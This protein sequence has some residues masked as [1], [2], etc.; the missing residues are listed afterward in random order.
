MTA[1]RRNRSKTKRQRK[2]S[3]ARIK[4]ATSKSHKRLRRPR[5]FYN[6]RLEEALKD[7]RNGSSLAAAARKIGVPPGQLRRYI[8][9]TGVAEF[10][11]KK[12][13]FNADRRLRRLPIYSNGQRVVITVR[14]LKTA[15]RVGA[16][17]SAV[18]QFFETEDIDYL[19]PFKGQSVK[20][21][22]GKRYPFE[23]RPNVL[24]SLDAAGIEPFEIVYAIVKPE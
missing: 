19:A 6:P 22:K 9:S 7:V 15:R 23:V 13:K 5:K 17:M 20:D 14:D 11:N 18:K 4:P 3:T 16:Y 1:K 12:W 2:R 8:E 21:V 10:R 24:F